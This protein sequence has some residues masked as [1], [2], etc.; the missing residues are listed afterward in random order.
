MNQFFFQQGK[1]RELLSFPHIVELALKK[2]NTIELG[3]CC[4]TITDSLRIYYVIEGKFEWMIHEQQHILYPGDV[5]M[6]LPG[7]KFCGSKGFLDIGTLSWII[8]K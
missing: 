5:T 6:I 2:N 1:S 8:L 4:V 7:Q 3:S